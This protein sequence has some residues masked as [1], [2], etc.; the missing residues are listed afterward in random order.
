MSMADNSKEDDI[1]DSSTSRTASDEV[2]SS[3]VSPPPAVLARRKLAASNTSTTLG[4]EAMKMSLLESHLK[5]VEEIQYDAVAQ[6]KRKDE[7]IV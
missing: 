5:T 6:R 2:L 7:R 3:I 4:Q 1:E